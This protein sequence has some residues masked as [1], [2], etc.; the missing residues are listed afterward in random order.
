MTDSNDILAEAAVLLPDAEIELAETLRASEEST[1]L[2]VRARGSTDGPGPRT[3]IVKRFATAGDGAAA[4]E[5]A[6]EGWVRE[7]AALA[8][9]PP[10]TPAP[11]LVASAA[12]PPLVVMTD[13]GT[14]PSVADALLSG[15]AAEATAALEGFADALAAFHL[16]TLG[17]GDSFRA[18]L[19]ARS[20]GTVTPAAMPSVA[21]G[22]A[23]S[24]GTWCERLG[25]PV[26]EG[27][28]PA[29]A[30]L[31]DQVSASGPCSLTPADICPDN[32]I[33]GD[34]GYVLI[35]FEGA[36]WRPVAWDA[37][38]LTV[39][40][41]T[42]WCSFGIPET[43]TDRILDR[44]RTAVAATLPYAATPGFA[45]DVALAT[46]GWALIS[47][48]WFIGNALGGDPPQHDVV[49][50]LP[51]RR[52][53][54]L[55]RLATARETAPVPEL[56]ELAGRLRAELTRRWGEVPLEYAPAFRGN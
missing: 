33:R 44:Y 51:T 21:A 17:I 9:M 40:W 20:G 14:G 25:V 41:P 5:T 30:E 3:L 34:R 31:P 42:C 49:A 43:V 45:R 7:R 35:D 10:G 19:A 48:A 24:L 12:S 26:P 47:T 22:A 18:E 4:R 28:L 56:A 53:R 2:R 55:D 11:R 32:N 54:I 52:A 23:A 46:T 6:A 39:P 38:Y 29:L 1:V 8:V 27:A 16:G 37:A 15:S 50:G 13:A 36:E